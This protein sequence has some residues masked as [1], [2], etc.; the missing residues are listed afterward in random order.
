MD[1]VYIILTVLLIG[2][3]LKLKFVKIYSTVISCQKSCVQASAWWL[4]L[5]DY[6]LQN[7]FQSVTYISI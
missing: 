7:I 3:G 5:V 4:I 1:L 6:P 2:I